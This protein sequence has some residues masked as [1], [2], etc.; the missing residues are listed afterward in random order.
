MAGTTRPVDLAPEYS[1]HRVELVREI[2]GLEKW[3]AAFET[4]HVSQKPAEVIVSTPV[5]VP[6][7]QPEP[8]AEPTGAVV[9]GSPPPDFQSEVA[10]QHGKEQVVATNTQQEMAE[11]L[12]RA[13][14]IQ[15]LERWLLERQLG[16][17]VD[18]VVGAFDHVG[19][20]AC[21]QWLPTLQVMP[22]EDM[23]AFIRTLVPASRAANRS[24]RG[25]RRMPEPQLLL[26]KPDGETIQ[27]LYARR[28]ELVSR[29]ESLK[30]QQEPATMTATTPR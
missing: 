20:I 30:A 9:T 2:A 23:K 8:E 16:V 21:D 1:R 10:G 27:R 18:V 24:P 17:P 7:P 4:R 19:G 5:P 22:D 13:Q 15:E 11:K 14:K 3:V 28:A 12:A 29:M 25:S 6:A 26:M